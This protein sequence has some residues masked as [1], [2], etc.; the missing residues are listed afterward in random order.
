VKG[1]AKQS[2]GRNPEKERKT[3]G[4][5]FRKRKRMRKCSG[6]KELGFDA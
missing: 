6:R 5:G 4:T 2:L 3:Q 1:K